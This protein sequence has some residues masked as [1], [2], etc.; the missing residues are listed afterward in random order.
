MQRCLRLADFLLS[1]VVLDR[2]RQLPAGNKDG[3]SRDPFRKCPTECYAAQISKRGQGFIYHGLG[4][5]YPALCS[6]VP[7]HSQRCSREVVARKDRE[8]IV[9]KPGERVERGTGVEETR[10][11]G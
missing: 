9:L 1:V 5:L 7:G 2:I 4:N 8:S 11:L 10:L 6:Y 3:R